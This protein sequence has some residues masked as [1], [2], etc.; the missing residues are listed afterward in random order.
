MI[1]RRSIVPVLSVTVIVLAGALVALV[2]TQPDRYRAEVITYLQNKTGKQIQ[3]TRLAVSLF[4]AVSIRAY[5]FSV[6]NPTP[7]PPGYFITAPTL[8]AE[9]D[10]GALLLHRRIVIKSLVLEAPSDKCHS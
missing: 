2:L 3:L 5:D 9:I 4:P 1:S 10:V 8:D 7:F 6:K